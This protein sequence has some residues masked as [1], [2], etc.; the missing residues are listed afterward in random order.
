MLEG[1]AKGSKRPVGRPHYL[2]GRPPLLHLSP[3][4]LLR[5][6][7][8]NKEKEE[9]EKRKEKEE[10]ESVRGKK[11]ERRGRGEACL[12]GQPDQLVGRP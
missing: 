12:V 3:C 6:E 5:N 2:V 11:K 9:R 1:A 8:K 7:A 10:H 4:A